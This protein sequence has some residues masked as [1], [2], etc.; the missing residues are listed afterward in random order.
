M[1]PTERAWKA[2]ERASRWHQGSGIHAD[3]CYTLTEYFEALARGI[4]KLEDGEDFYELEK[5]PR[6][7]SCLRVA[8]LWADAAEAEAQH[9]ENVQGDWG[10]GTDASVNKWKRGISGKAWAK[11]VKA[12]KK[13]IKGFDFDDWC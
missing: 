7:S 1:K 2:S 12:S 13:L 6:K 4:D 5:Q 8:G 10:D 11:A 3:S 9:L